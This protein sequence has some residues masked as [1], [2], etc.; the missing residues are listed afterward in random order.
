MPQE[1]NLG[2]MVRVDR[3]L[4]EEPKDAENF[5]SQIRKKKSKSQISTLISS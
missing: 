5:Q 4:L 2:K 1:P 3:P